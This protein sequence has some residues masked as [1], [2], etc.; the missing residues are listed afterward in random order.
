MT[1]NTCE[2]IVSVQTVFTEDS[3][4]FRISTKWSLEG[5]CLIYNTS[6]SIANSLNRTTLLN[7]TLK[8]IGKGC[9]QSST[10]HAIC[11]CHFACY[12]CYKE[13]EQNGAHK[14]SGVGVLMTP[15]T[16]FGYK[17]RSKQ[18]TTH[19]SC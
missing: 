19:K 13:P 3:I 16:S 11:A 7:C 1:D 2:S 5:P 6:I 4:W 10:L 12:L 15:E 14:M 9:F 8:N 18:S 17:K